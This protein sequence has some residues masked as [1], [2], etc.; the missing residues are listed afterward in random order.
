MRH[1]ALGP[2]TAGAAHLWDGSCAE[3]CQLHAA[4]CAVCLTEA[5]PCSFRADLCT[6]HNELD[7]HA[8]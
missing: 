7:N 2:S 4:F 8:T 3:W 6:V 1:R 5:R